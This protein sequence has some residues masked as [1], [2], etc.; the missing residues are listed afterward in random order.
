LA[1]DTTPK[2]ANSVIPLKSFAFIALLRPAFPARRAFSSLAKYKMQSG[3]RR[4]RHPSK[5][6]GRNRYQ[7]WLSEFT[8]QSLFFGQPLSTG[9][10]VTA[11]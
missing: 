4:V 9:G 6:K 11:E 2:S 7:A 8:R 1:E 10:D 5:T 3:W